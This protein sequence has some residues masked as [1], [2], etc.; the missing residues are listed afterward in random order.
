MGRGSLKTALRGLDMTIILLSDDAKSSMRHVAFGSYQG[1][2]HLIARL[3]VS[4]QASTM[5]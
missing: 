5:H 2:C 1:I 3:V 4:E